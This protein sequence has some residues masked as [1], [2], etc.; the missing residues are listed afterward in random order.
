MHP[1]VQARLVAQADRDD[2]RRWPGHRSGRRERVQ[3]HVRERCRR[4]SEADG[5]H[6]GDAT[7]RQ[8]EAR[9]VPHRARDDDRRPRTPLNVLKGMSP[10]CA[11]GRRSPSR[12]RRRRARARATA[13]AAYPA[14]R[15]SSA[16]N[17]HANAIPHNSSGP[18]SAA[19]DRQP[20]M[21]HGQPCPG[22]R[23]TGRHQPQHPEWEQPQQRQRPGEDRAPMTAPNVPNQLGRRA[24]CP[25][26]PSCPCA[27]GGYLVTQEP[28]RTIV[29]AA[30]A[31]R[32]DV[33]A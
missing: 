17:D 10:G 24:P 11:D 25:P 21:R 6:D 12:P 26:A 19:K 2:S 3:R 29:Q 15:P 22:G 5:R 27:G 7:P 28:H 32:D 9:P 1:H 16:S 18:R 13:G 23:A 14:N 33:L 8:P 30:V 4:Q 31:Q 20:S